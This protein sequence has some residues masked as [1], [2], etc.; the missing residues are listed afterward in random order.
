MKSKIIK[1]IFFFLLRP[2][3]IFITMTWYAIKAGEIGHILEKKDKN[4]LMF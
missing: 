3:A 4:S 2:Q 1:S